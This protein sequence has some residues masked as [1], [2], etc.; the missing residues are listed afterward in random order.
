MYQM[1]MFNG[2]AVHVPRPYYPGT[3]VNSGY[4]EYDRS[5]GVAGQSP[6]LTADHCECRLHV[7]G[8][9]PMQSVEAE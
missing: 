9:M 1:I 8:P 5:L 3:L 7:Q 2:A 4:S 6:L